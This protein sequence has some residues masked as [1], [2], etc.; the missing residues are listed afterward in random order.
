MAIL[1]V[2]YKQGVRFDEAYYVTKHLP[3]AGGVMGPHGV[4][5][6][7]IVKVKT[8][9]DGSKPPYQVM[10]TAHFASEIGLRNALQDPQ[11]AE[12]LSDIQNFYDG[13]PDVLIGE[14]V[15]LP[16]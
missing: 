9:A 5:N 10:F 3:L 16:A 8:A 14:V 7:E 13:V 2:C 15:P 6:V 12:V 4:T 11:M 1:R